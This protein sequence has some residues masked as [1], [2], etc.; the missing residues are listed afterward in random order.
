MRSPLQARFPPCSYIKI[1]GYMKPHG[2]TEIPKGAH[3]WGNQV[4]LAGNNFQKAETLLLHL[5]ASS[6]QQ[7]N[8]LWLVSRMCIPWKLLS[9]SGFRLLQA[10]TAA[11]CRAR[12]PPLPPPTVNQIGSGKDTDFFGTSVSTFPLL[13]RG[14]CQFIFSFSKAQ[15]TC[16]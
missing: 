9:S 1:Y 15:T 12:Q 16:H 5:N 3:I 14:N 7:L 6:D 8:H 13:C 4:S 10:P 11:T 2:G